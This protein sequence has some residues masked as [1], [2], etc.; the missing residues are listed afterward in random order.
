MDSPPHRAHQL[1]QS[2]VA[3]NGVDSD[4]DNNDVDSDNE[5]YSSSDDGDND[6]VHNDVDI[7]AVAVEVPYISHISTRNKPVVAEVEATIYREDAHYQYEHPPTALD[8]EAVPLS[9]M[10]WLD[11]KHICLLAKCLCYGAVVTQDERSIVSMQVDSIALCCSVLVVIFSAILLADKAPLWRV[12]IE[13]KIPSNKYD[14]AVYLR[15]GYC[16]A[17]NGGSAACIRWY[18]ML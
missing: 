13:L 12:H 11:M 4:D 5:E 7:E 17:V 18:D 16:S 8:A 14:Y 6:Y 15:R 1:P 2:T 10:R 9:R 3:V